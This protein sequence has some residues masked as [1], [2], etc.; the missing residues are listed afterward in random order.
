V[1]LA[2]EV[3]CKRYHLLKIWSPAPNAHHRAKAVPRPAGPKISPC[4]AFGHIAVLRLL[5]QPPG[6]FPQTGANA[7]CQVV[8]DLSRTIPT[9][10]LPV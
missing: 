7:L 2:E 3:P 6:Q 4:G 8:G 9:T 5:H 10:S 1:H